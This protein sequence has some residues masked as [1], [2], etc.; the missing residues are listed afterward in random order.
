[1]VTDLFGLAMALA[2]IQL[3]DRANKNRQRTFGLY[4][5]EIL[6]ALGNSVLLIGVGIYVLYEAVKRLGDPVDVLSGPML[7]VALVGLAAN[8][9]AFLLLRDG[10]DQSLNV[11]GAYLEVLSDLLGSI[12]VVI[13][14]LIIATTGWTYADPLMGVAIG[15]FI[16]PRA[17]RLGMQSLRVLLQEAPT[18]LDVA[19]IEGALTGIRGVV[20]VHDLHAWTL[21]S[22]ME[23][24]SAHLVVARG[25]ETHR[26]LD[27]ARSL[28]EDGYGVTH[29]TLQVEPADHEGCSKTPW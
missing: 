16:V 20:D 12:G 15:V 3:A 26:V 25:D 19:A 9:I 22:G 21:T 4:R 2:A 5:L 6:A 23:V 13:A 1:M 24:A 28:L 7:A 17:V 29:A 18:T 10:A 11:R 14:A 27:E 8:V